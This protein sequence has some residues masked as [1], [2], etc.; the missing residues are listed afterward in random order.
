MGPVEVLRATVQLAVE[1]ELFA[2][3]VECS[4]PRVMRE[5]GI[6]VTESLRD[7]RLQRIVTV[8]G[9]IA[10]VVNVLRPAEPVQVWPAIVPGHACSKTLQGGLV[11]VSCGAIVEDVRSFVSNVSHFNRSIPCHLVLQSY[12]IGINGRQCLFEWQRA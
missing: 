7:F 12:V 5:E 3:V 10:E 4:L 11:D 1:E 8:V 2:D 6:T 9:A